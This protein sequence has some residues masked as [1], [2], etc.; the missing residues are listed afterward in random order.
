MIAGARLD[1]PAQGLGRLK[2]M[3]VAD[4]DALEQAQVDGLVEGGVELAH[5]R[6]SLFP[7][8]LVP[9]MLAQGG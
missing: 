6:Q 2:H 8:Q 3:G 4:V 1:N 9:A 7:Q 5:E